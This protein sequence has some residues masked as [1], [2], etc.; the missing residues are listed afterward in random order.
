MNDGVFL[1]GM[2]AGFALGSGYWLLLFAAW[3]RWGK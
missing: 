1:M 2:A 3:I